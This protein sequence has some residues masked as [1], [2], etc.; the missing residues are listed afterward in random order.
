MGDSVLIAFL[1]RLCGGESNGISGVVG[2]DFL[3]RLCGGEYTV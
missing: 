3:S 2:V 1:S